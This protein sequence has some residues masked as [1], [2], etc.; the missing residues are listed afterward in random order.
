MSEATTNTPAVEHAVSRAHHPFSPSKLQNLEACPCYESAQG[1]LN[2]RCIAGT[3]AH[4]VTETG[5]DE[6]RLS[7]DDA[8]AAAECMDFYHR[9]ALLMR[10]ARRRAV[11]ELAEQHWEETHR[12]LS[13][14]A[15]LQWAQVNIPEVIELTESYLPID[16]CKFT[17]RGET[18]EA[19]TAGYV[20]RAV[21]DHTG[22]F[23]KMFDWKFGMWPVEDAANNLQGIAYCLGLMRLYP[24]LDIIQFFFKQPHINVVSSAKFHRYQLP[25]LY[26]RIQVV[27]A[28]AVEARDNGDWKAA[29]PMTPVC[30]FCSNLGKCPKVAQIACNVAHKFAPMLVPANVTPTFCD[31]PENTEAALN[32]SAVMATWAGAY[33]TQVTDR[34]IRRAAPV[35]P[36]FTLTSRANR[37]VVSEAKLREVTLRYLTADE[38]AGISSFPFGKAEEI[39]NDKAPRGQKKLKIEEYQAALIESGAVIKGQPYAFLRAVA[40]K[41]NKE[42]S[43]GE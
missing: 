15:C 42:Q 43:S 3:M 31:S 14:D 4:A 25:G 39:V 10:E 1:A 28:R 13:P 29:N 17:C 20:D 35:P 34:V 27:V 9:E 41:D 7:D 36:G 22:K 26:L 18:V 38:L 19:T 37:E 12:L 2:A 5:E 33:R 40:K 6:H 16:G 11:K 32:L 24:E 8:A 30:N 23:A 21:I